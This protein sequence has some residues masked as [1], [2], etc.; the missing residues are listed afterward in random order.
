MTYSHFFINIKS[1]IAFQNHA[2][3]PTFPFCMARLVSPFLSILAPSSAWCKMLLVP[4]CD[5]TLFVVAANKAIPAH[6]RKKWKKVPKETCWTLVTRG[7]YM[8]DICLA[9][10]WIMEYICICSSICPARCES[11]WE[12]IALNLIHWGGEKIYT[13][14]WTG[15]TIGGV[16]SKYHTDP[17]LSAI[18]GRYPLPNHIESDGTGCYQEIKSKYLRLTIIRQNSRPKQNVGFSL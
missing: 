11:F 4:I 8:T 16:P 15:N 10:G 9:R 2:V 1:N 13:Q 14:H 5:A 17:N 12:F 3:H 18:F 6:T 7:G